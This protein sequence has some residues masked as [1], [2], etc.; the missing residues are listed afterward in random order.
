MKHLLLTLFMGALGLSLPVETLFGQEEAA[1]QTIRVDGLTDW[2]DPGEW[3]SEEDGVVIAESKGGESLPKTHFL[4]WNGSLEGDFELQL[5]YR[6]VATAPQ[7]AGV[8]FRT[9]RSRGINEHGNLIGYQAE[10]DT[11]VL[12][13]KQ[14]WIREG[15]L[16]GHIHDG[17][18]HRMFKRGNRVAID[19]SGDETVTPLPQKF[20][21]AKVFRKPPEW[22]VC[23]IRIQGDL[24]QLYLN[25]QLANEIVDQDPKLKSTGDA[26]ALQFRPPNAYRFEVRNIRHRP[27]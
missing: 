12:Y 6:I 15:K 11:A 13:G 2:S 18:R 25:G 23:L 7:D 27:F 20:L 1:W 21:P 16:F 8:Y 9:D 24:I 14:K 10:L 17:K 4:V 22:N 5:E 3:W 19:P 26:L